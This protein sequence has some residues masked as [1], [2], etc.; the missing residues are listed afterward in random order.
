VAHPNNRVMLTGLYGATWYVGGLLAALITY[1]SQYIDSTWS[2]RLPSLVSQFPC[3]ENNW[4]FLTIIQLQFLPSILCLIP[5]PFL[6]E[7][8]RWL[9]YHDRHDEAKA[10]LIKYHGNGDPNSSVV[11]I[12]FEEICQTLSYEKSV[13][14]TEWKALVN[15]P[16]NRWRLGVVAG[17]ACELYPSIQFSSCQSSNSTLSSLLSGQW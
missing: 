7:S 10:M 14:K 4:I 15:T 16:A 12:E 5:L 17:V 8:P 11:A 6:P 2:W 9:I 13:Q 1:G 3:L